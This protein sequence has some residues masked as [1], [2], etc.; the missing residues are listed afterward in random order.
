MVAIR[1]PGKL[2]LC[3]DPR[4]Q[5]K[6]TKCPKYQMPTMEE[7]MPILSKAWI[8]TVLDANLLKMAFIR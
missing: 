2:R 8:F 6:E 1:K 5:N 7:L 4:D 3:I